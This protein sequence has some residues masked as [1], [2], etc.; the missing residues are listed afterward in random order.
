MSR[1]LCKRWRGGR[2]GTGSS[3]R[4]AASRLTI[5]NGSYLR[6]PWTF[7]GREPV[8]VQRHLCHACTKSYSEQSALLVRSSWYAREVHRSAVDHWQHGRMSLRR[9][10][11][12]MRSWLGRQERWRLWRRGPSWSGLTQLCTNTAKISPT[13]GGTES[14]RC[15]SHPSV[16]KSSRCTVYVQLLLSSIQFRATNPWAHSTRPSQLPS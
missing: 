14:P 9:T 10:A 11:E 16:L 7:R 3:V 8:W 12:F 6:Q 2:R 4:R 15:H 5:K 1:R 13:Q